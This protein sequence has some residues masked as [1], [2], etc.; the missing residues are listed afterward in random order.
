M[1]ER[2]VQ[3]EKKSVFFCLNARGEKKEE[4]VLDHFTWFLSFL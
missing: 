2:E 4:N 3:I 1:R